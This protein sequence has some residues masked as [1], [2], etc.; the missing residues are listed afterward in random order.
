MKRSCPSQRILHACLVG[1]AVGFVGA[2]P[3]LQAATTP[4]LQPQLALR[5]LTPGEIAAYKVPEGQGASGLS[6]IGLGQPAYLEVLA[7]SAF[8][9]SNVVDVTWALAGQPVGATATLQNSPLGPEVPPYKM[10]ERTATH[11]QG[12]RLLRPDLAGQYTVVATVNTSTGATNLTQIINAGTYLGV[13]TCALCHSGSELVANKVTPWEKTGHAELFKLGIDGI[14]SDHYSQSCISCHTV[15]YDLNT[16]AVNGGFDDVATSLNWTFPA[17]TTNGNWAKLPDQLKNLA[18]I[19]CENCHGPGSQHAFSFGDPAKIS[20]N[21]AAGDCA[22][23]H[24]RPP[25]HAKNAEWNNSRHAIAVEETEAGCSRCH[26]AQ[27]FVNYAKGAPAVATPYEVITC[28]ACHEPHDGTNP[29][30]LRAV[31]AITLMDNKTTITEGGLGL[32]CMNCHMS[33]RDAATYV[34]T[35]PGSS[36]FGPHHGPQ[37]DMLAGANAVTYGKAIPSSAHSLVIEDSCVTCHMHEM[38]ETSPAFTHAG[39]HTFAM[40]WEGSGTNGP[41]HLTGSCVGCHGNI[42]SF[43]FKR[44][45][46]DGDGI[47]DGVQTEV[48]HLLDKLALLLPPVGT[49]KTSLNIT[50]TWTK[51]QLK[52][53]Y[54]YQFVLEDGSFGVHNLAYAIGLLKA[55]I[56]DLTGDANNDG[57]P[58]SWQVQYFGSITN[59]NAAPNACPAG[60]G[61]PNWLKYG[62]GV[63]PTI[64]GTAL[65]N[66]VVWGN[67]TAFGDTN[68]IHIYTAAEIA[69]DTEV[70]KTYQ[71]QSIASMSDGWSNIGS[72]IAGTGK[73]ISYVTPT[74]NSSTGQQYYRVVS[75]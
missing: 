40:T 45:D 52:A 62:L 42:D 25:H 33:R 23:C 19:Q 66:G 34:E 6:T 75:Q 24:D 73:S 43:D 54:N 4:A 1:A 53:A 47:V 9:S 65:A 39:G 12:R 57:L 72:P 67:V 20:V 49:P 2:G 22:Q 48:K 71:I 63:D 58:D 8:P 55:S 7:N 5:P 41:V 44:Q 60:D 74:R 46:Y 28:G 13:H 37:A 59:P 70:G 21:L 26:S 27:G 30:Q 35:T 36:R 17:V 29:H 16:N 14:A 56:A 64:P 68:T 38:A 69:F 31:K 10:A 61:V 11:V 32:M 50:A 51:P 15:G 3:R 18:N